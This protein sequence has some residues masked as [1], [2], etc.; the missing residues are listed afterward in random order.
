MALSLLWVRKAGHLTG[1]PG[2]FSSVPIASFVRVDAALGRDE[3]DSFHLDAGQ[4][5][6]QPREINMSAF[7]AAQ[8]T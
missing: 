6:D 5:F 8:C 4:A 1:G 3:F 2:T 7:R